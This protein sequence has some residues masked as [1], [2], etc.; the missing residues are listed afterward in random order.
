[1]EKEPKYISITVAGYALVSTIKALADGGLTEF[2]ITKE[3]N[4]LVIRIPT[5]KLRWSN[6]YKKHLEVSENHE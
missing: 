6:L 5:E 2:T 4:D 3:D 1:M